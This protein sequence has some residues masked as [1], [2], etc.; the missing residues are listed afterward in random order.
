MFAAATPITING[1]PIGP[2]GYGM[3]SKDRLWGGDM[4]TRRRRH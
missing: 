2:V 4:P 1:K 3:M